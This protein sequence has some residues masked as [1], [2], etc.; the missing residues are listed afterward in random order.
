MIS[1]SSIQFKKRIIFLIELSLEMTI[2]I[3]KKLYEE[4]WRIPR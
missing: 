4:S 3:F 2:H 1:K